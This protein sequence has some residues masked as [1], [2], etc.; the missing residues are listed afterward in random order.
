[1]AFGVLALLVKALVTLLARAF[2]L[3]LT[4]LPQTHGDQRVAGHPGRG[5]LVGIIVS[6]GT[7]EAST[8]TNVSNVDLSLKGKAMSSLLMALALERW[9]LRVAG[10]DTQRKTERTELASSERRGDTGTR[11][12]E[13]RV[14]M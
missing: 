1:M 9:D 6:S 14:R 5:G 8:E 12:S 11:Q 4:R 13:G 2:L 7:T 3:L 10:G